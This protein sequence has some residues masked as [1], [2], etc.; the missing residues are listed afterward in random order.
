MV[1]T[2]GASSCWLVSFLKT[3]LRREA[4]WVSTL[5]AMKSSLSLD[6]SFT[7]TLS[8]RREREREREGEREGE[9]KRERKR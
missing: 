5:K 7:S 4:G 8:V 1:S 2:R 3:H 9:R 6:F